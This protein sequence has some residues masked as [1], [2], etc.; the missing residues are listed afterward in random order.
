MERVQNLRKRIHIGLGFILVS[1]MALVTTACPEVASA[2]QLPT[3]EPAAPILIVA[4][5]NGWTTSIGASSHFGGTLA[6]SDSILVPS[7]EL[8]ARGSFFLRNVGGFLT[9]GFALGAIT[10]PDT[11]VESY[12]V[13]SYANGPT[14]TQFAV[15][16]LTHA[17]TVS[18]ARG[19]LPD[20]LNDGT[21]GTFLVFFNASQVTGGGT[22]KVYDRDNQLVGTEFVT[23]P[24]GLS[25]YTLLTPI[26]A[27]RLVLLNGYDHFASPEVT[28]YAF[29]AIGNPDGHNQRIVT[30]RALLNE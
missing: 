29:A 14:R 13:L 11:A 6:F 28:V 1:L 22:L 4:N 25:T 24:R 26:T 5:G 30:L 15:P 27:G 21:D 3:L 9:P 7:A 10:E 20:I 12:S 23:L 8:G 19:E 18:G 16:A 17:L 2:A